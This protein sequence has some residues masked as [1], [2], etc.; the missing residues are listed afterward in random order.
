MPYS[1][2]VEIVG[3]RGGKKDGVE[4]TVVLDEPFPPTP[5]ADLRYIFVDK[6]NNGAGKKR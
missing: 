3:P 6:T 5:E 4:R 2:Q 1:G